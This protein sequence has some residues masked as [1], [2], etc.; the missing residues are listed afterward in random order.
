[1]NLATLAEVFRRYCWTLPSAFL[2][3]RHAFARRTFVART[4][5]PAGALA[6]TRG[7]AGSRVFG[8]YLQVIRMHV[9]IIAFGAVHAARRES[10]AVYA[11][12]YAVYFFP[13]RL[14]RQRAAA[15][16][17]PVLVQGA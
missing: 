8:P 6:G 2:A 16:T 14:L 3:R 5:G 12:V 17:T 15:D 10:F 13:W 7:L 11:A 1:M 9:I 4:G